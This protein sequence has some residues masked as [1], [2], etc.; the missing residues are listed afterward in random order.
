M[1]TLTHIQKVKVENQTI[2]QR[3]MQLLK[4]DDLQYGE[5]QASMGYIYL[6][7]EIEDSQMI[8]VLIEQKSYWSWWINHWVKRDRI[9][10]ENHPR[11]RGEITEKAYKLAHNPNAVTFRLHK[12]ILRHSYAEMM[13]KLIKQAVNE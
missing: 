2:K 9:F 8:Q 7:A 13:G 6:Q 4:W 5:F 3:V 10:L 1:E 12:T 11:H